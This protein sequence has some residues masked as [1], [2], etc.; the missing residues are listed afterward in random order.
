MKI[1]GG[2]RE[3]L[4]SRLA[5]CFPSIHSQTR[6]LA[7]SQTACAAFTLVELLVV[8]AMLMVLIGSASSA[9]LSAQ[10]RAK[11]AKATAGVQEMTNA[12]LA[13]EN[14]VKDGEMPAGFESWTD[15]N[16]GKMGFILGKAGKGEFGDVPVLYNGEVRGGQLVDPWGMPYRVMIRKGTL[17]TSDKILKNSMKS[18]VYFPNMYR[19]LAGGE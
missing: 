16:E 18:N 2:G 10:K 11:I 1:H 14:M 12:I 15:A 9:V 17:A 3:A 4:S 8:I 6:K 5:S 7:N 13:Y 19:I